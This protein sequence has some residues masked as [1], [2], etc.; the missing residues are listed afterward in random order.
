MRTILL[1]FLLTLPA[2]A[3]DYTFLGSYKQHSLQGNRLVVESDNRALVLETYQGGVVKVVVGEEESVP[4]SL[5]L[6][7][8]VTPSVTAGAD[9]LVVSTAECRVEITK[10][11]LRLSIYRADGSLVLRDD[12]AFG[13]GWNGN[14]VRSWKALEPEMKFYGLGEKSGDVN[15]SGRFFTNWNADTPAYRN[16]SDP[17]YCNIPFFSGVV[18][19]RAFGLFFLTR[20]GRLS[21]LEPA[22]SDSTL[23]VPRTGDCPTTCS[24]VQI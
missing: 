2:W 1:I 11:P 17:L 5:A 16:D 24:V 15:R 7:K 8:T 19:G 6:P 23:S 22:T 4:L 14:E 18:K 13:H 21:I 9:E 3:Q 20:T 12:P 10:E